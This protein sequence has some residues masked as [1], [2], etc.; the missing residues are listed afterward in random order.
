MSKWPR[1]PLWLF[2]FLVLLVLFLLYV[3]TGDNTITNELTSGES[4]AERKRKA[5]IRHRE[6]EQIIAQKQIKKSKLQ[7]RFLWVYCSLSTFIV[8]IVGVLL[9][10]LH[11]FLEGR[12]IGN[13]FEW[14]TAGT[15][16]I[17][18]LYYIFL[19]KKVSFFGIVNYFRTMI[20]NSVYGKFV[21]IDAEIEEHKTEMKSLSSMVDK[22]G[23]IPM[24][25]K[26]QSNISGNST[27][28]KT[29]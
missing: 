14:S 4:F 5:E 28:Q 26:E 13:V 3:A 12:N 17:V 7:R 20:E 25:I 18:G 24:P 15:G 29:G 22:S 1:F 6:L 16:I 10:G 21:G 9:I 11:L 23:A 2:I 19:K 27:K 8:A